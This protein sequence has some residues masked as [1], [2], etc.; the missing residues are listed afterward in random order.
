MD[1]AVLQRLERDLL[2]V[3]WERENL[4]LETTLSFPVLTERDRVSYFLHVVGGP[5]NDRRIFVPTHRITVRSDFA[6]TGDYVLEPFE[7]GIPVPPDF[8]IGRSVSTM[9]REEFQAR[10]LQYDELMIRLFSSWQAGDG[11]PQTRDRKAA[12]RRI[13]DEIVDEPLRPAYANLN[14]AFFGWLWQE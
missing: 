7:R 2:G 8:P 14:P 13:F 3:V 10:R 4:T 12:F 1:G 6:E 9:T 5:A 11:S